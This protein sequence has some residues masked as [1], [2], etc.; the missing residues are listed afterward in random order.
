MSEAGKPRKEVDAMSNAEMIPTSCIWLAPDQMSVKPSSEMVELL[1]NE[2][3]K[4]GELVTV[5][6]SPKLPVG[7]YAILR[8]V[9]TFLAAKTAGR[10]EVACQIE[11]GYSFFQE[12]RQV[13]DPIEWAKMAQQLIEQGYSMMRVIEE[14]HIPRSVVLDRMRALKSIK[15]K[16]AFDRDTKRRL[17]RELSRFTEDPILFARKCKSIMDEF[18]EVTIS[19]IA[20]DCEV[21]LNTVEDRLSMLEAVNQAEQHGKVLGR[22]EKVV[23]ENQRAIL[24]RHTKC[25]KCGSFTDLAGLKRNGGTCVACADGNIVKCKHCPMM[26]NTVLAG[27]G[28]CGGCAK[29]ELAKSPK[30]RGLVLCLEPACKVWITGKPS[31]NQRILGIKEK[32]HFCK[33]H[34]KVI[35]AHPGGMGG[36]ILVHRSYDNYPLRDR[37]GDPIWIGARYNVEK[38]HNLDIGHLLNCINLL[39]K[40][41]EKREY[42]T[43]YKKEKALAEMPRYP[44]LIEELKQRDRCKECKG[45]LVLREEQVIRDQVEVSESTVSYCKCKL[46]QER[47]AANA[48]AEQAKGKDKSAIILFALAFITAMLNA[49]AASEHVMEMVRLV[50]ERLRAMGVLK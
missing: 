9:A 26:I 14:S 45:G 43:G 2:S 46:G 24:S 4:Q 28:M 11:H 8:G 6:R 30:E 44:L 48:I 5:H 36:T 35:T 47:K 16:E 18:P 12:M 40:N 17:L 49:P 21:G 20:I 37:D 39:E 3:V 50:H 38:L 10:K 13:E 19:Q 27:D 32:E 41:A 42:H 29:K 33:K 22:Q 7:H 15:E 23:E 1:K 31:K 34:Q 25:P